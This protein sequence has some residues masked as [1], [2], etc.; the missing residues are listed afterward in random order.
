MK[1]SRGGTM[2]RNGHT[3]ST[4]RT[5]AAALFLWGARQTG[6]TTYLR[7]TFPSANYYQ[8]L[9]DTLLGFTLEPWRKRRKRRLAETAKFYLFDIGVANHLHPEGADVAEG[10]DRFERA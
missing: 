7:R 9:E 8:I 1:G 2:N 6:K 5:G 3:A 10:S 4:A